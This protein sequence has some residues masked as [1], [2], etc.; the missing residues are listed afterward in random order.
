MLPK[1]ILAR[2]V[3]S[4]WVLFVVF[5]SVAFGAGTA[6][7]KQPMDVQTQIDSFKS[8]ALQSLVRE[9]VEKLQGMDVPKQIEGAEFLLDLKNEPLLVWALTQSAG[10]FPAIDALKKR[11]L[12]LADA[13]WLALSA[14]LNAPESVNSPDSEALTASKARAMR[15]GEV[16][17]K[18]IGRPFVEPVRYTR[19]SFKEWLLERTRQAQKAASAEKER[20]LRLELLLAEIEGF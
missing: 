10:A 11:N 4:A 12:S 7:E 9:A 14:L 13:R 5:G 1:T 2:L 6:G 17:C 8:K 18:V 15:L 19:V 16:Y 3:L 20:R